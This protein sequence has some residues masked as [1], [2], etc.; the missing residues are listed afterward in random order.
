MD[1]ECQH[2][3]KMDRLCLA[4]KSDARVA[5]GGRPIMFKGISDTLNERESSYGNYNRQCIITQNI[6]KAMMG[7][8]NWD[9]LSAD[10]KESLSMIAVKI[11]RILNGDPNYKDSWHD[12][13][14]YAKLIADVLKDKKTY[15]CEKKTDLPPF[16]FSKMIEI[17]YCNTCEKKVDHT[18]KEIS[19]EGARVYVCNQCGHAVDPIGTG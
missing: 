17:L 1:E 8:A 7:A 4:C 18:F 3:I 10:K 19:S 16:K 6:K 2:G 15:T 9:K 14:G 5:E 11:G 12:I 13:E